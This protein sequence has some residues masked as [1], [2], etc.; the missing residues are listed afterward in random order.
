MLKFIQKMTAHFSLLEL[1]AT[2]V[3]YESLII[4]TLWFHIA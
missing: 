1:Q 3:Q 2:Q 4:N